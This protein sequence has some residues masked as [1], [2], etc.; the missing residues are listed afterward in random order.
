MVVNQVPLNEISNGK[1]LPRQLASLSRSF[2]QY[3]GIR[4][5]IVRF[6]L[7]QL[8]TL[9]RAWLTLHSDG[10]ETQAQDSL[11]RTQQRGVIAQ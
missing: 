3:T 2:P 11:K 6:Q 8:L 9:V 10:A 4:K 7:C 5:H 1:S